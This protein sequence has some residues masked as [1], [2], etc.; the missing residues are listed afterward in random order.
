MLSRGR[1]ARDED[2]ASTVAFVL[3]FPVFIGIVLA[4]AE[5]GWLM[6]RYMMVERGVDIAMR[7]VRLG[8]AG[9][10]VTYTELVDRICDATSVVDDC[11]TNLVVATQVLEDDA[12]AVDPDPAPCFDNSFSASEIASFNPADEYEE[13]ETSQTVV[14]KV[15]AVV[16]PIFKDFG[17]S[18][19]LRLD[20]AG[21][22]PIRTASAFKHEP[23]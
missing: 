15:C 9:D 8:L 22:F 21:G 16:Q 19:V 5:A 1:R 12:E 13:A 20:G 23:Y 7:D 4:G 6:T 17:L 18:A 14:V 2:G 11:S 3:I 10:E